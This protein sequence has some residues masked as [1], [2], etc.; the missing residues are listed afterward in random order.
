[1]DWF[2]NAMVLGVCLTNVNGIC[3]TA[4]LLQSQ[5]PD[6][7]CSSSLYGSGHFTFQTAYGR[8]LGSAKI[9]VYFITELQRIEEYLVNDAVVVCGLKSTGVV[10]VGG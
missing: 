3:L 4:S 2:E 10:G 6:L 1:M 9:I 5:V 8:D 7:N